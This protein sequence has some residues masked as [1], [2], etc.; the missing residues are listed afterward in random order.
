M[1]DDTIVKKHYAYSFRVDY[2]HDCSKVMLTKLDE[3][4]GKSKVVHCLIFTEIAEK[5]KKLHYQGIVW[6][7]Q[8]PT[9]K[10]LTKYRNWW[11]RP[12]GS[13]SLVSAK[14]IISLS[15][16]VA[17]DKEIIKTSLSPAQMALIPE[18]KLD[19][20]KVW[21]DQVEEKAKQLVSE[22]NGKYDYVNALVDYYIVSGKAPP[23][24]NTIYKFLL[25]NHPDFD[26]ADYIHDLGMFRQKV[27][28]YSNY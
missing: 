24:R 25:R 14:K 23:T 2:V 15:S 20:K 22:T 3:W 9:G 5:T 28:Q 18:W 6:F 11:C 27:P 7:K 16:Y 13:I 8:K 12:Q 4:L 19:Q 17:K 26:A 1:E 21:K 10:N